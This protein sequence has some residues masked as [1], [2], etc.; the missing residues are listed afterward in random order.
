MGFVNKDG[1]ERKAAYAAR[2][3][4]ENAKIDTLTAE[5]HDT[6][7]WLCSVRHKIHTNQESFFWAESGAFDELWKYIDEKINNTLSACGLEPIPFG[8]SLDVWTD[9]LIF[10]LKDE[11]VEEC[12]DQYE[13]SEESD[14]ATLLSAGLEIMYD[15]VGEYNKQI[16]AYLQNIDEKH[17]T[18]YAPTCATRLY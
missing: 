16:E 17:G 11:F 1:Y 10:E 2:K 13:L 14:M 8:S 9:S 12:G 6:L 7:A 5:Q 3:N 15:K 18:R 4:L